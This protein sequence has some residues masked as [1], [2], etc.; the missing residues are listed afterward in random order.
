VLAAGELNRLVSFHTVSGSNLLPLASTCSWVPPIAVTSGS[1]AGQATA[2]CRKNVAAKPCGVR[3]FAVVEP[4][5]DVLAV[6]LGQVHRHLP[7]GRLAGPDGLGE[8]VDAGVGLG[9]DGDPVVLGVG[10]AA[11]L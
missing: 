9:L 6:R 4:A 7:G 3:V 8:P 1:V 2:R 5:R 11:P 10:G